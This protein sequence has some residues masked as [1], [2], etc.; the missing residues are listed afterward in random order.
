MQVSKCYY[1]EY[2][3]LKC[4]ALK[5]SVLNTRILNI[6]PFDARPLN[7]PEGDFKTGEYFLYA[8]KI[9]RKMT[10]ANTPE[11]PPRGFRGRI[12]R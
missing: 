6:R 3:A 12:F 10:L 11:V 2:L 1:P 9:A 4:P 5:C 7:P 8:L